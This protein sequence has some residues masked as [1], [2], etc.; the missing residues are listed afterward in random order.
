V[1][2]IK[3]DFKIKTGHEEGNLTSNN[4]AKVSQETTKHNFSEEQ[5]DQNIKNYIDCN[6]DGMVDNEN[7][8]N[9]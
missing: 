9:D 5:L 2:N 3:N 1:F 4:T 7:M 6:L 8:K